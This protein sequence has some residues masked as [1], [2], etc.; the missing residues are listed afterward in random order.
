MIRMTRMIRVSTAAAVAVAVWCCSATLSAQTAAPDRLATPTKVDVNVSLGGYS[1]VEPGDLRISIDGLK[2]G[3]EFTGAVS[4]NKTHRW[5]A[6]ANVRGLVGNTSYTG[7]CMPWLIR[8]NSASPNGY[9]LGLGPASA[10]SGTGDKDWYMETRGLVGK[11][12]I[13]RAWAVSPY[14]GVGFRHLSNGTTGNPGYRTDNYLYLPFGAT[15]RTEVASHHVLSLNL[16]YDVLARGWQTTRNSLLGS[17]TVPATPTA[18]AFVINGFADVSFD[19]HGGWALRTSGK[20]ELTRRWS[21]EPYYIRWNVD[22]STVSDAVIAFTVNN[23]TAHQQ[24]HAYEPTNFTN[25]FG[26]KL[27]LRFR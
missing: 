12:V 14:S 8:P 3:G 22:D 4:L 16:E 24:F 26:V 5:F 15:L 10:C 13:G 27:G 23:V 9:E 7:W 6:Q 17:G 2:V 21:V 1:Y 19:Q 11:D 20:Y 18:P 25:E